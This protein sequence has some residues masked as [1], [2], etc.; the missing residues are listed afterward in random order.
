MS[1]LVGDTSRLFFKTHPNFKDASVFYKKEIGSTNDWA[2]EIAFSDEV[3]NSD[4][5]LV[6][7]DFQTHGRGR[8]THSWS[9]DIAGASLLSSW[10]FDLDSTPSPVTSIRVGL[11]LYSACVATWPNGHFSLKAPND[12]YL[13][14]KKVAGILIENIQ[15]G[16][17]NK[18]IIGIG[19]NVFSAPD[20]GASSNFGATSLNTACEISIQNWNMFLEKLF[21]ELKIAVNDKALTLNLTNRQS[22]LNALNQ[23]PNLKE[24]Y[25]SLEPDGSLVL[26]NSKIH[27]R[28]L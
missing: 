24:K 25:I 23:N 28:D 13:G 4:F 22:V 19:L 15:Q 26:T 17:K 5:A 16:S 11:A 20:L 2:K 12:L 1:F 8:G 9:T 18:L 7:T 21:T 10:I 27:W 3:I 14:E 6:L